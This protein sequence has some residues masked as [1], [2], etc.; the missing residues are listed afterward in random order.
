[1]NIFNFFRSCSI[2]NDARMELKNQGV[3]NNSEI[4]TVKYKNVSYTRTKYINGCIKWCLSFSDFCK[5]RKSV[6]VSGTQLEEIYTSMIRDMKI[7]KIY[8]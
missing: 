1:M 7:E 5:S 3:I 6:V 8:E 2:I 4:S